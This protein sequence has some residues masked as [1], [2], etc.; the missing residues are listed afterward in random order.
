MAWALDGCCMG[1]LI[2]QRH[3]DSHDQDLQVRLICGCCF[4]IVHLLP[5]SLYRIYMNVY[6]TLCSTL[7]NKYLI[8][9]TIFHCIFILILLLLC[10]TYFIYLSIFLF[11]IT[12]FCILQRIFSITW[13]LC[14]CHISLYH[15]LYPTVWSTLYLKKN[16]KHTYA[17]NYQQYESPMNCIVL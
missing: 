8:V 6:T 2:H 9:H 12:A 14:F 7:Q 3:R 4:S 17:D 13:F 16:Q 10:F 15:Q 5:C 11:Y 1:L